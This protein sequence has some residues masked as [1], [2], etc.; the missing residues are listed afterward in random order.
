MKNQKVMKVVKKLGEHVIIDN[1]D[2]ASYLF[3]HEV[4]QPKNLEGFKKKIETKK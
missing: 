1:V 3:I 2:T 4:K